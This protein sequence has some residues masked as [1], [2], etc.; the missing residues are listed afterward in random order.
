MRLLLV[1]AT[2]FEIAPTTEWLLAAGGQQRENVLTFPR[3]SV[4]VIVTGVGLTA[5]AFALGH[6][7]GAAPP[8]QLAVQAGIAGAFDRTLAPGE[9]VEVTSE[10]FLDLGAEDADGT[11]LSLANIGLPPGPPFTDDGRLEQL[12]V[13][14]LPYRR[15]AGGTVH[16]ASGSAATIEK[17]RAKY[18]AVATESM[19]GGAF[20]YACARAGV[21]WT[22]LRAISNYVE[23]RNR[24]NWR[25]GEAIGGLNAALQRLLSPFIS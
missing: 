2:P 22:Q 18:P 7:F 19:E 15:C 11:F 14:G 10:T 1:S 24:D 23:P 21:N 5:T 13:S 6:R 9:V 4:E 3:C 25:M 17:I 8:P 16:R 20:V 12:H